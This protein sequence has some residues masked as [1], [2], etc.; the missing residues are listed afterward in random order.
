M[1]DKINIGRGEERFGAITY[2]L[3]SEWTGLALNTVRAYATRGLFDPNDIE[4]TLIW[5]NARR[6]ADKKKPIGIPNHGEEQDS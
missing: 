1:V 2:S 6:A 5:V 4:A 3:I